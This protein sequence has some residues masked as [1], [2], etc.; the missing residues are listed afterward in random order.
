MPHQVRERF[1]YSLMTTDDLLIACLIRCASVDD[2][3]ARIRARRVAGQGTRR[4]EQ[5][6]R[7]TRGRPA[8]GASGRPGQQRRGA[9]LETTLALH[10][11]A[12]DDH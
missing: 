3:T 10:L 2:R 1:E 11:I 4:L 6:D 12:F 7:G 9:K 5:R 8:G